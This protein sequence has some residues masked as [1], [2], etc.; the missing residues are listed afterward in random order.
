MN[1]K[2]EKYKVEIPLHR[3]AED[4]YGFSEVKKESSNS[5][6]K[7]AD[8]NNNKYIFQRNPRGQYRYWATSDDNDKGTI[9]DFVGH[10]EG[11]DPKRS[12]GRSEILKII[13]EKTNDLDTHKFQSSHIVEKKEIDP[14]LDFITRSQQEF[15]FSHLDNYQYLN[16]RGITSQTIESPTF[17][18]SMFHVQK[19]GNSHRNVGFPMYDHKNQ[20]VGMVQR[21]YSFKHEPENNLWRRISKKPMLDGSKN[22]QG[23]WFSKFDASKPID[24]III[25][26]SGIDSM[27]HYQLKGGDKENNLYASFHGY[28][29]EYKV[30][31]MNYLIQDKFKP[32]EVVFAADNGGG[33]YRHYIAFRSDF[34]G[35]T[36]GIQTFKDHP[37]F[38]NA[39][40]E[41]TFK[42]NRVPTSL[43][44][45]DLPHPNEAA[46]LKDANK[47]LEY[48]KE[49]NQDNK[50]D[51]EGDDIYKITTTLR[52]ATRTRIEIGFSNTNENWNDAMNL[53]DQMKPYKGVSV[54]L[55][56]MDKDFNEELVEKWKEQ[57][58]K[59]GKYGLQ[60]PSEFRQDP[61][62]AHDN[63]LAY[64]NA[65]NT[66]LNQEG[67]KTVIDYLNKEGLEIRNRSEAVDVVIQSTIDNRPD[68]AFAITKMADIHERYLNNTAPKEIYQALNGS[69]GKQMHFLSVGDKLEK[70]ANL[71]LGKDVAKEFGV[72]VGRDTQIEGSGMKM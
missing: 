56:L 10:R 23:W 17:K 48:F 61:K 22:N 69:Y 40:F 16:N 38:H 30:R 55:P 58:V 31:M 72:A 51:G 1:D 52:D 34:K 67:V 57:G 7:M 21:Y 19:N 26:E 49:I 45:V 35:D 8:P 54:D 24:K 11:I 50:I 18:G 36:E 28:L 59:E 33:G 41:A 64:L 13:G 25:S 29:S 44:V 12:E 47:V 14:K 43:L 63:T 27:S 4:Y 71:E 46:G 70:A 68:V 42:E 62:V 37:S 6:I 32:K 15:K 2:F 20:I 5:S 60:L 65:T 53:V 39:R 9:I 66:K 3:F